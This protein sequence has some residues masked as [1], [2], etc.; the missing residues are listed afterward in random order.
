MLPAIFPP[1]LR[2]DAVEETFEE[3]ECRVAGGTMSTRA[4]TRSKK[5]SLAE[6]SEA[7][8]ERESVDEAG[9]EEWELYGEFLPVVVS[10]SS[11]IST[12][13]IVKSWKEEEEEEY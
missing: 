12:L 6:E 2:K 11:T 13:T 9:E 8:E 4:A 7:T 3:M 5:D 10:L 1:R